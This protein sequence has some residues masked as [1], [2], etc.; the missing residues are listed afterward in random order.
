M[1]VLKQI[2]KSKQARRIVSFLQKFPASTEREIY[3]HIETI[4]SYWNNK[5]VADALRRA[6]VKGYVHRGKDVGKGKRWVYYAA[7][8]TYPKVDDF[9]S[10]Q[11]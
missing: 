11:F 5:A 4:E 6:M 8:C 3:D 7:R 9:V 2:R 10:A 1:Q